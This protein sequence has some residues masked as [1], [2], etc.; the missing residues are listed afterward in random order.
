MISAQEAAKGVGPAYRKRL[1][2]ASKAQAAAAQRVKE[3]EDLLSMRQKEL[4]AAQ[5]AAAVVSAADPAQLWQGRALA[6]TLAD[7]LATIEQDLQAARQEAL[8]TAQHTQ[9]II[10]E[11]QTRQQRIAALDRDIAKLQAERDKLAAQLAAR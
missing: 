4:D 6:A 5:P 11:I 2:Q 1:E 3:L 8:R 7:V 9:K 10:G